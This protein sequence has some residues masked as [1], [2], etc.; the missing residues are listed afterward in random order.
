MSQIVYLR[1]LDGT[2]SLNACSKG[3]PGAIAHVPI[4]LADN[5]DRDLS[6]GIES[7]EIEVPIGN[8]VIS[9]MK[10]A[11]TTYRKAKGE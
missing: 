4:D 2:G 11:L 3:D 8:E 10:K 9:N 5:M 7:F 1:D 6:E